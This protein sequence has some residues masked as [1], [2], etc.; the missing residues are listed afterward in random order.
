MTSVMFERVLLLLYVLIGAK[1]ADF[2][3]ISTS[4]NF[5]MRTNQRRIREHQ[6]LVCGA[7]FPPIV[8]GAIHD[9][10]SRCQQIVRKV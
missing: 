1:R 9:A 7:N 8:T 10:A 5:L 6:D 4:V 2:S 3:T